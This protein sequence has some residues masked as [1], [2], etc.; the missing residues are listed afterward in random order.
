MNFGMALHILMALAYNPGLWLPSDQLAKSISV[1]PVTVRRVLRA[2]SN[3]GL[4]RSSVGAGG[5]S[6]LA[7]PP[8]QISVQ[9]VYAAIGE[10]GLLPAHGRDVYEVCPV[11][12]CM[13]G[14]FDEINQQ[15][16]E[17]C[18]PALQQLTL[19]HFLKDHLNIQS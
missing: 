8:E 3:A 11:S 19:A 15:L 16:R 4:I 9:D 6:Q 12:T 13:P 18:K 7:L 10:P 1:N 17:V 2:L 5:G 14:V